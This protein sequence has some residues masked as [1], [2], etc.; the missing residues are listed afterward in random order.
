MRRVIMFALAVSAVV[1][2][3]PSTAQQSSPSPAA[4][5]G[6]IVRVF[7]A[8]LRGI[9]LTDAEKAGV[10]AVRQ[11][12]APKFQAL[13][14]GTQPIRQQ[15]RAARQANDTVTAR[16]LAKQVRENRRAGVALLRQ[17]LTDV[18]TKLA[19]E[20][21]PQFDKNLVRVRRM[22]RARFGPG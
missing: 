15:L 2:A 10:T 5:P 20:H 18:R 13:A 17:S 14:K 1:R 9:P 3:T 21:Q 4:R 19:P 12:Y 11:E 8:S 22:V 16:A 7:R 6:P